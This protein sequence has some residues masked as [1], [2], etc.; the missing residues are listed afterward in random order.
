MKK[1][2]REN[3]KVC[4]LDYANC[5]ASATHF[6]SFLAEAG[7]VKTRGNYLADLFLKLRVH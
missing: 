5:P 2:F 4:Y 3:G 7:S 6:A 1:T